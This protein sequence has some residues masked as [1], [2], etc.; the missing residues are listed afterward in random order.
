M[1]DNDTINKIKSAVE[2][3]EQNVFIKMESTIN[4][5]FVDFLCFRRNEPHYRRSI[6]TDTHK[7]SVDI[8]NSL[9]L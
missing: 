2:L 5:D 7:P 9:C 8:I 1:H 6:N 4:G 3:N